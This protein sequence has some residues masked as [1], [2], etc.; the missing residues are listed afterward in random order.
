M[1]TRTTSLLSQWG[2]DSTTDIV[3]FEKISILVLSVGHFSQKLYAQID[4]MPIKIKPT[5]KV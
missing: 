1:R 5:S 4:P 2:G 3:T